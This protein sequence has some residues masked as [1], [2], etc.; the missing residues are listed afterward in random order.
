ML[1]IYISRD[2]KM[3]VAERFIDSLVSKYGKH[4]IHIQ[5]V[6]Q[7]ILKYSTFLSK[8]HIFSPFEKNMIERM[9]QYLR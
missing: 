1:G 9:M 7:E 6:V 3:F 5:M 8:T 4:T 2:D